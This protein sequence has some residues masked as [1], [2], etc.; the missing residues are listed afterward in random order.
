MKK[1]FFPVLLLVLL[2]GLPLAGILVAG[3]PISQYCEFP[4]LTRYVSHAQVSWILFT[5]LAVFGVLIG[6]LLLIQVSV[7]PGSRQGETKQTHFYHFPWWAISGL[8]LTIVSWILA[9]NRFSWFAPFQSHTFIP[10]WLG[11]ILIVNG[12]TFFRSGTCLLTDRTIYFYSLF[13]VSSLFWW[14]FEYLNRFVQN[15]YYVGVEDFSVARYVITASISFSTVLPAVVSVNELLKGS[16]G[17]KDAFGD[18]W[19]I[20]ISRPCL[21]ALPAL[22][23]SSAGLYLMGLYPDILF[24][25]LWISPLVIITSM[26]GLFGIRT[27]FH[28]IVTGSWTGICR[29]A[30]SGIIC[31]FFW[32]MWNYFS[33]AKWIYS[34]PYVGRFKIFEMPL[35]GYAGYLP[36]GLECAVISSIVIGLDEIMGHDS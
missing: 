35:L 15:W 7:K 11:Y 5:V 16:P 1:I 34:I 36:F 22:I 24:S 14:F 31:G 10:L 27:V 6:A 8:L 4:P 20:R 13:P 26:H 9:W 2:I 30:V 23:V 33:Y 29:L 19:A 18:F 32:E 28:Q 21:V 3:K 17:F 25:L 12:L